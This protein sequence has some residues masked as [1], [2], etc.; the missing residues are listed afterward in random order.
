MSL[1]ALF[2]LIIL[3]LSFFLPAK[4]N[5]FALGE[6]PQKNKNLNKDTFVKK[7]LSPKLKVSNPYDSLVFHSVRKLKSSSGTKSV[8]FSKDMRFLYAMNLEG[9]SI[10]EFSQSTKEITRVFK[11]KKTLGLVWGFFYFGYLL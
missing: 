8:V 11:F 3:L 10:M 7:Q 5:D 9:M 6:N 1:A 2:Q 4:C